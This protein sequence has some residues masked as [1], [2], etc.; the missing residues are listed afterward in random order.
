MAARKIPTEMRAA[1]MDHFGAPD[2]VHTEKLPVPKVG[3]NDI[4]VHV[5]IAGVGTWDPELVDGS[6]QDTK[7]RFPRVLGSDGAGTVVAV[8]SNVDRFKVGDRVYGWGFGNP[9]GGFFAEYAAIAEHDAAEI[10]DTIPIDEAGALAVCGIT[11]LQGLEHLSLEEGDSVIIF[12]AGGGV[13]H[14]AV[15]LANRMGLRVFAIA[16]GDDGVELVRSLGADGAAEGHS[17]SLVR[18]LRDFAPEGFDGAL[19]CSGANGW[20][21]ELECVVKGGVVA[22]PNGVE[23][24]PKVP[25]G[26]K[27]KVYDGEDTEAAFVRLNE[28][29]EQAPFHV[30]LSKTYPL[31]A[32]AQALRDVQRHH[33]GKLAIK[34]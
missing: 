5:S 7:I 6:F 10:P 16:S 26:V 14:I 11:A 33:L 27:R 1:A 25:K 23:P 31:E 30:E 9:K 4:L 21:K 28:L 34:I 22:F 3:K 2:V 17:K 8:G 18:Q 24:E 12:G 13:G 20:A 32:T 15:Q 19:V 29:V